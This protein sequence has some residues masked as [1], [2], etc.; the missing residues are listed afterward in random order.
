MLFRSHEG[1]NDY[2]LN[3]N[4]P[5][6]LAIWGTYWR[7]YYYPNPSPNSFYS[8]NTDYEPYGI[9]NPENYYAWTWG[10]ALFVVLDVYRYQ[11]INSD[12]PQNWD[13]S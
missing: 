12:K 3:Q 8:G 5:N 10:D 6:N 13:W 11:N 4:P 1:E 2:Y 7:K 9:G